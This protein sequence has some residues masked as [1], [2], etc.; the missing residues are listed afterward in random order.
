VLRVNVQQESG[1]AKAYYRQGEYYAEGL[2]LAGEWGGRAA[3]KLGLV[4]EVEKG[5][6][7]A[8]CD[9]RDPQDA[10]PLTAR[11][12][13]KRRV[14]FDLNFHVPKS[15]SVLYGLFGDDAI[16]TAFQTAV[17]ETMVEI[18]SE[19]RTRVR[20][21]GREETRLTANIVYARFVHTTARPVN[22]VPD[23][24]LHAHCCV[25]NAT[26]DERENAWKAIEL[27]EV[28]ASLPYYEAAFHARFAK[29][30][31]QLGFDVSRT[32][33]GW[34]ISGVPDRVLKAFSRRTEKI[35]AMALE[36]GIADAKVK[37]ALGSKTRERKRKDLSLAELR[38]EWFGR[39]TPEER[40]AL[41]FVNNREVPLT[42]LDVNTARDAMAWAIEHTFERE[43]VV[44][45]RKLLASAL[46]FGVGFVTV[47]DLVQEF[48][49]HDLLIREK[50]GRQLVTTK[51]VLDEE[52]RMLAFARSG[53]GRCLPL[54]SYLSPVD[55]SS[56]GY[57][58]RA[59]VRHLL[60]SPD[61]VMLVRGAAGTGKTAL[62]KTAVEAIRANGKRVV[63]LAPSADASRG[64]LRSEGF[65]E[66]DTVA[67]FLADERLQASAH[68][69]V[70]WIDE[71]GLVGT[72]SLA[73]VFQLAG[74]L[75]ARIIL[76]GDVRQHGPVD[77]GLPLRL[78][79]TEAGM[80]SA[81]IK[82]IRRQGGRYRDA[83]RLLSDGLTIEG[84][85]VLADL[86]W[87]REVG[88]G[89][90]NAILADEYHVNLASG[91]TAL[92]VAP[93]HAEGRLVTD[94]IRST[95]RDS[96]L[97]ATDEHVYTRLVVKNLTV[98]ERRLPTHYA[99]GDAIEFQ[100]RAP[101]FHLGVRY[102]VSRVGRSSVA[103]V[104]AS[105]LASVL[106]LKHAERFSVY[107][108]HAIPIAVGDRIRITK[109]GWSVGRKSRLDNGRLDTVTGFTADGEIELTS[110]AV[111]GRDF[112]HFAHGYA[113]TS[114]ASQ[115]KTVDRVLLAVSSL[116]FPATGKEQFY[117][118]ASRGRER[119]TVFTDDRDALRT[120]ILRSD[121]KTSAT[122]LVR[123]GATSLVAWRAWVARRVESV[124]RGVRG[125]AQTLIDLAIAPAVNRDEIRRGP[126]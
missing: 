49:R 60:T 18:E 94:A 95:L 29:S 122:E 58:Q 119:V 33:T 5:A 84:F 46:R 25:F 112:G 77:R 22:G 79:E 41:R 59:A 106:P 116:S 71:A 43:S 23:P 114:L 78:L 120:A 6:F 75:D 35:E 30:I 85:D 87:V 64:V 99:I 3:E 13:I 38:A 45:V 121:P 19:T 55:D 81:E 97:L 96:G 4:G 48:P 100:T 7:A 109:N 11:T 31:G 103:V 123:D 65:A 26:I 56:L 57:E 63:T 21:G 126:A 107:T 91:K 24:H 102:T 90:R 83:V 52:A 108:S 98:A 9:N 1:A 20:R 110:R 27:G 92:V 62:M 40:K 61:R 37:D 17:S 70:L 53:R 113:I 69:Q 66:A 115:G 54:G 111:L 86:G 82:T 93:T 14:L 2:E 16:L 44:P 72:R 51:V 73:K 67:K 15:V 32:R 101:G 12:R 28:Y 42:D 88:D 10:S 8:L 47:N 36:L 76:S 74:A 105:G 125:A 50:D 89:E 118:S 104:D 80:V 68:G 117:V 34:E 39:L 124:R